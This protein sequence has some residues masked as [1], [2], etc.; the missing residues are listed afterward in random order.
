MRMP[1][2]K[3]SASVSFPEHAST[4]AAI[5]SSATRHAIST[6]PEETLEDVANVCVTLL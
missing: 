6:L 4:I 1:T 5:A 3:P 2:D